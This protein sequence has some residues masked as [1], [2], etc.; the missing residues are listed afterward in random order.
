MLN[1]SGGL[2]TLVDGINTNSYK[3]SLKSVHCGIPQGS[4]M[5]PLLFILYVNDFEQCK[6]TPNRYADDTSAT[7]STEDIDDRCNDLKTETANISEWLSQNKLSLNTDKIEY[8][9]VSYTRQTNRI[10]VP[11]EANVNG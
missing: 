5:G 2:R 3:S 6:C 1:L 10:L 8:M 9:V 7:C 4:C 11:L